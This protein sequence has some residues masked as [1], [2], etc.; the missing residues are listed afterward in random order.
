MVIIKLNRI[1]R[2]VKQEEVF[3]NKIA[4]N[5]AEGATITHYRLKYVNSFEKE[6]RKIS[7]YCKKWDRH[8]NNR[9]N[10]N[11]YDVACYDTR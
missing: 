8:E 5:Y 3:E 4:N 1:K 6:I 2:K 11:R 9:A 10:R 7:V